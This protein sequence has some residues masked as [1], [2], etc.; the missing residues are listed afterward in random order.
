MCQR[1]EKDMLIY[2]PSST[3]I[4]SSFIAHTQDDLYCHG[5]R[6]KGLLF[7]FKEGHPHKKPIRRSRVSKEDSK[8]QISYSTPVREDTGQGSRRTGH[9]KSISYGDLVG[10]KEPL[11]WDRTRPQ[12]SILL[13]P[14]KSTPLSSM[15]LSS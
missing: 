8:K 11:G 12:R 14:T 5:L 15:K 7:K 13:V 9:C 1:H 6:Y 10:E 3:I 4:S 2:P